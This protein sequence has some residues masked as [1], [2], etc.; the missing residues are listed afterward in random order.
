MIII[1]A[2]ATPYEHVNMITK[3]NADDKTM[4]AKPIDVI[5]QRAIELRH[6]F[7]QA[8]IASKVWLGVWRTRARGFPP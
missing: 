4:I 7:L 3:K 1:T 5:D 6:V 2:S 8:E